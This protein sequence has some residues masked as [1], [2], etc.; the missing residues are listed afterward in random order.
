MN[1]TFYKLPEIKQKK[2]WRAIYEEF[3]EYSYNDASTNRIIEKAGISKGTLYNYFKSKE[4]MHEAIINHA[5]DYFMKQG[6]HN[7]KTDDFIERCYHVAKEKLRIYEESP[8]IIDFLVHLHLS[9]DDVVSKEVK[10][11]IGAMMAKS[12]SRLYENVDLSL[13]RTDVT[14]TISMRLIRY[15][16]D[17]Y[18]N[19][20]TARMK[21]EQHTPEIFHTL[22]REHYDLL[23]ELKKIYYQ[24]E[25]NTHD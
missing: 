13:F 24:Q 1:D 25:V 18:M 23:V 7:F 12:T 6:I 16:F 8:Y 20:I 17:G 19:E 4:G 9:D 10:E 22:L 2:I 11:K 5:W 21:I 14:S 15:T 3:T